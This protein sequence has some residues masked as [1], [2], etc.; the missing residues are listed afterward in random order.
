M[1]RQ[2]ETSNFNLVIFLTWNRRGCKEVMI[3]FA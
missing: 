2:D 1:Y 3:I